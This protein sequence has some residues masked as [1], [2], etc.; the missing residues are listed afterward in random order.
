MSYDRLES[1]V[2]SDIQEL[3]TPIAEIVFD[4]FTTGGHPIDWLQEVLGVTVDGALGPNTLGE[5]AKSDPLKTANS[6]LVKR[7]Q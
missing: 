6:F 7:D 2:V 5:A 3:P 4:T 1:C